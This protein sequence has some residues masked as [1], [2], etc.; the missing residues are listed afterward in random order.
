MKK[1]VKVSNDVMVLSLC[2]CVPSAS[3][4]DK[5]GQSWGDLHEN[6]TEEKKGFSAFGHC[7]EWRVPTVRACAQWKEGR[8]DEPFQLIQ[9]QIGGSALQCSETH[10]GHVTFI[11]TAPAPV[12]CI[13]LLQPH[14]FHTSPLCTGP[15]L[16]IQFLFWFFFASFLE[17]N[18]MNQIL[19]KE[20]LDGVCAC[21]RGTG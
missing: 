13:T 19:E 7:E 3:H 21:W 17:E 16:L 15:T 5:P 9:L 8:M 1:C 20:W 18:L 2:M 11:S 12:C 4:D 6:E 10:S 14:S